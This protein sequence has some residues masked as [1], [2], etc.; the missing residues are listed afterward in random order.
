MSLIEIEQFDHVARLTLNRPDKRNALSGELLDDL[1]AQIDRAS[2]DGDISVV[3]LRGA[4][5]G[6]SAGFDLGGGS[7]S[8]YSADRE[9]LRIMRRKL[10][11]VWECP[12]PTIAAV[13]GFA[14]AGG[15]DLALHCDLLLMSD[16]A[17]IGY[18]PVRNLG[19]PPTH[20]WLYRLGPQMT[21]RL[22]FTG[23]SLS[24]SEAVNAGLALHSC[25]ATQLDEEAMKLAQRIALVSR[26]CLVG[27]KS[28]VNQGIDLMGRSS[29]ARFALLEDVLAHSSPGAQQFREDAKRDG[30][31]QALR[32]R[33]APFDNPLAPPESGSE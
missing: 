31:V 14:L 17:K 20:M 24:G 8:N 9:R 33:D 10:E 12:I 22:L 28:V 2:S 6:F 7:S 16:D 11:S 19:V 32:H 3:V 4:G 18:P 21:K 29:L 23:D 5:K 25:E 13:H 26:E 30:L 27:N 1:V 15:A